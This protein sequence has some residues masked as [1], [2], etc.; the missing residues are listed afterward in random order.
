MKNFISAN[1][2]D[3]VDNNYVTETSKNARAPVDLKELD[4]G[5]EVKSFLQSKFQLLPKNCN[6][7]GCF[8]DNRKLNVFD[9]GNGS[10]SA[11]KK[12]DHDYHDKY[13]TR[14]GLPIVK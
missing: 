1:D 4:H 14:S 10:S 2:L 7:T 12:A 9:T 5:V 11:H 8:V 13:R 3:Q 6:F